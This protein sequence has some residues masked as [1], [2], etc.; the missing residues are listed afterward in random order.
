MFHI[1]NYEALQLYQPLKAWSI[2]KHQQ[3]VLKST[4]KILT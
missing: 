2:R 1:V 3:S 4:S